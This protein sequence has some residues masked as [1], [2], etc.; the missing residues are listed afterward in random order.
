MRLIRVQLLDPTST[1]T[2]TCSQG[3]D[4]RMA[5]VGGMFGAGIYLAEDFSKSNQ[6]IPCPMCKRNAIFTQGACDCQYVQPAL[7]A[8]GDKLEHLSYSPLASR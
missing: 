5:S 6:Y 7:D 1:G 4:N 2:T 3:Y 8:T